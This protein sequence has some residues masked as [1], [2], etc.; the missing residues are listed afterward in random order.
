MAKTVGVLQLNSAIT[1]AL[2]DY[3]SDVEKGL[4]KVG[5]EVAEEAIQKLKATSPRKKGD[6]SK[7]WRLKRIA[8]GF[9]IHNATNYQL[10]HLLEKGH[11]RRG[12]G[13][14]VRAYKHIEPVEKAAIQDFIHRAEQVIKG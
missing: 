14:P 13:A 8:T 2:R 1:K 6:Y 5:K 9:V 12:G 7:G 10:T 4:E 3:S 11:A